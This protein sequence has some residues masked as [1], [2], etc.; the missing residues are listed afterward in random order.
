MAIIFNESGRPINATNPFPVSVTGSNAVEVEQL[1]TAQSIAAGSSLVVTVD[2]QSVADF[3]VLID[4]GDNYDLTY[5]PMIQE[6]SATLLPVQAQTMAAA[7]AAPA[8]GRADY[9]K[10]TAASY[11]PAHTGRFFIKNNGASP[12][13]CDFY[14]IT[15]PRRS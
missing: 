10:V 2:L 3:A 14:I 8:A 12:T 13:T 11:L 15:V 1:V 4:I 5:Y 7:R 9:F 6:S